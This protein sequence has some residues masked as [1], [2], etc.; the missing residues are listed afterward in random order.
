MNHTDYLIIGA[1]H[2]ALSALHTLRMHDADGAVTMVTRDDDA[3]VLADRAAL[4][5]VRPLG[6]P[7]ACS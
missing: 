7:S 1:S 4:R 2:A 3:A 6:S 5:G